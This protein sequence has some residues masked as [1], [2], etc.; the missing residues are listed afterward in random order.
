[1]TNELLNADL[2]FIFCLKL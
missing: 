2:F 1:M